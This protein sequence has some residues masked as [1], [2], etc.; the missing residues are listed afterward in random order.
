MDSNPE[1]DR[2]LP[3]KK[4]REE[5]E[6][7][8]ADDSLNDVELR[9]EMT[10]LARAWAFSSL[11]WLWGP[12][13]YRRNPIMFR[14]FISRYF[15]TWKRTRF[16]YSPIR[17]RGEVA[18]HL[19]PWLQEVDAADDIRLFQLLYNWKN[20]MR[21]SDKAIRS[22]LLEMFDKAE[23]PAARQVVLD[24]FQ[25][26]FAMDEPTACAIYKQEPKMSANFLQYRIPTGSWGEQKR[27]PWSE[28]LALA[29]KQ[30][31]KKFSGL[32]YRNRIPIKDWESDLEKA[33]QE[34]RNPDDLNDWLKRHHP[35]GWGLKLGP[36]YVKV[37]FA[38][39]KDVFPYFF[40]H[41]DSMGRGLIFDGSFKKIKKLAE[42]NEWWDLWTA[43]I[44]IAGTDKEFNE[45]VSDQLNNSSKKDAVVRLKML[46]GVSRELNFSSFGLARIHALTDDV[47]VKLYD[48]YPDLVRRLFKANLQSTNWTRYPKLTKTVLHADDEI[49]IDFL[50]GR[51]VTHIS[52][53]S[54]KKK[55]IVNEVEMLMDYFE[56]MKSDPVRFAERAAAV[57]AQVPAFTIVNYR[58]L[59]RDNKLA[60]MLFEQSPR[61]FLSSP[62][63]ICELIEAQEIH[64]MGL[65]Y[66]VIALDDPR[67]REA[68]SANLE[69]LMGI[70]LRPIHRKTRLPA[71]QA[72]LNAATNQRDAARI[73]N[74]AREAM[75]LPDKKYP[76]EQ[77]IGLI[78]RLLHRWPEL[79]EPSE[80]PVIYRSV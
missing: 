58:D 76:K 65:A 44:R 22:R 57:L 1:I 5:V 77:L 38:R 55:D 52:Y 68:A 47:A 8:L 50:A 73:L 59:M 29:E 36:G 62:L 71:F 7:L 54:N 27:K 75:D 46:S 16:S 4:V 39:G 63:A 78:G 15:G 53:Y 32:V 34:I 80:R 18:K 43:L 12:A 69:L 67:A 3:L 30:D 61:D 41:L 31:D 17:W 66:R 33:C 6:R 26:W 74:K 79:Q 2:N 35:H 10:N 24:K 28:L 9:S 56:G 37:I 60:R 49:M 70:L 45:A 64:V 40:Q 14:S 72:L 21:W 25:I 11:T 20:Q 19:D 23:S 42:K 48:S 51:A 13:L